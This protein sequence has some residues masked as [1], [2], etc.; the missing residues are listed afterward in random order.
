M[1]GAPWS[2][3][4]RQVVII[5]RHLHFHSPLPRGAFEQVRWYM[6]GA[7][8]RLENAPCPSS[9]PPWVPGDPMD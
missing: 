7:T 5:S 8:D 3:L 2:D 4:P 1:G 6:H 9:Q